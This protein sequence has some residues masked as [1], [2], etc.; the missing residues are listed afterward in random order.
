MKLSIAVDLGEG[1]FTVTTN[2]YAVVAWERKFKRRASE[3]ATG[4]G[5]E[6]LAYM[7]YEACKAQKVIVPAL[8]DDFV[9]QL[10]TLDVITQETTNPTTGGPTDED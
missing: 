10:V 8:F 6:D 7:A 9:K 3:L 4:V 5:V 1:P 2:L